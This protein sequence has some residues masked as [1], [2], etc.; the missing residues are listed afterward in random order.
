MEQLFSFYFNLFSQVPVTVHYVLSNTL[1]G[2]LPVNSNQVLMSCFPVLGNLP[3]LIPDTAWPSV[4]Q[5]PS[6]ASALHPL[7][8]GSSGDTENT[9]SFLL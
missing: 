9:D 8:F 6:P 1:R 2:I 5:S 7:P 3:A 4:I